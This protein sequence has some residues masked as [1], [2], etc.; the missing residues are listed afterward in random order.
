MRLL[1]WERGRYSFYKTESLLLLLSEFQTFTDRLKLGPW[2]VTY[3]HTHL[4]SL[5]NA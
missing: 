2:A 3:F 4:F 1:P 5:L